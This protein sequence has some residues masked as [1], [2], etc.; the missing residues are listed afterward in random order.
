MLPYGY[1]VSLVLTLIPPIWRKV[2][3]PISIATNKKEKVT[4][5]F[6]REQDKWI[7]GTLVTVSIIL[8]YV[9]FFHY[10]FKTTP[11]L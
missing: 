9:C 2:I 3:D 8:T 5:E 10:G 4:E 11:T 6:K 1:S 7:L